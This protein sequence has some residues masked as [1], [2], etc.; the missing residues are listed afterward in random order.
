MNGDFWTLLATIWFFC[1]VWNL[2]WFWG[3][4]HRLWIWAL[5]SLVLGPLIS[6]YLLLSPAKLEGDRDGP[7]AFLVFLVQGRTRHDPQK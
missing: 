7:L 3:T 2:Y 4:A 1:L 6:A 5:L